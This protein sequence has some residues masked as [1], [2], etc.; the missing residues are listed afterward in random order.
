[1]REDD[2]EIANMLLNIAED[3]FDDDICTP[4]EFGTS[5]IAAY[6]QIVMEYVEPECIQKVFKDTAE[7]LEKMPASEE[8]N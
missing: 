4:Y 6:V 1:M 3:F 7:L 2:G 8:I 5:L